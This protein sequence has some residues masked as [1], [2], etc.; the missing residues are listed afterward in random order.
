MKTILAHKQHGYTYTY[1]RSK[2]ACN[3]NLP[4]RFQLFVLINDA[5]EKSMFP[6]S[7]ISCFIQFKIWDFEQK[8]LL[9][10]SKTLMEYIK[11]EKYIFFPM[12]ICYGSKIGFL[13]LI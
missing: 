4:I 8:F 5:L 11:V 12:S 2:Y 7:N 1:Q 3:N 10:M 6:N 13:I 9:K